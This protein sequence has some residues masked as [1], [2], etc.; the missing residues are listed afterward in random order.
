[1]IK[2][3]PKFWLSAQIEWS[4]NSLQV[5]EALA[6]LEAEGVKDKDDSSSGMPSSCP[7]SLSPAV[8][9]PALLPT[10]PL[11]DPGPRMGIGFSDIYQCVSS[12]PEPGPVQWAYH[13]KQK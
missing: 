1:M 13:L 5:L 2:G 4:L 11:S 6:V 10:L 7:D 8:V 12:S 9:C 3:S